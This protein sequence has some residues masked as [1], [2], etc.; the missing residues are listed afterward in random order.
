MVVSSSPAKRSPTALSMAPPERGVSSS[1]STVSQL[2][3]KVRL[4]LE[5]NNRSRRS[6][7]F[8]AS[9]AVISW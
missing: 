7:A 5:T 9:A 8:S 4:R 2:V 6:G 3:S 1:R